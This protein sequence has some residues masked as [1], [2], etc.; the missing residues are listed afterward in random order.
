MHVIRYGVS[1][2]LSHVMDYR[3]ISPTLWSIFRS[4]P[5]YGVSSY[6]SNVMEYLQISPTLW[7]IFRSLPRRNIP[8]N[9]AIERCDFNQICFKYMA[10]IK[11]KEMRSLFDGVEC[12]FQ[13][14]FS[15]I[16]VVSFIGGGN[17]STQFVASHR[18]TFSHNV[19]YLDSVGLGIC[20]RYLTSGR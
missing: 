9:G 11:H 3:Q 20:M 12:H 14:Y 16:V 8:I 15:Y 4:L 1:S 17:R 6:L 19:W 10:V 5:R 2:D 7:S 13:Q 18:Q